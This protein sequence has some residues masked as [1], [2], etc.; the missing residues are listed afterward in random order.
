MIDLH[1]APTPNGWKISIMLE[2]LGMPYNVIPV[3]IRNGDQFKPE[4]LAI[5]PNNR[6][7]AIVDHAPMDGGEPL[8]MFETGAIL[9]YLAE[10]S[11]RFLP[12]DLRARFNVIQWLMWQM[13]GL[14]PMLGQHG[15]FA[16]YAPEKIPY[17][18]QRYRDEASRLYAVLNKQLGKTGAYVAGEYSIADIACFPWTMTHKA[19]GFTLDDFPHIKRWYA[20]VRARPKVQAGLAVGK[21]EKKPF[22]EE[23]RANMFGKA[24]QAAQ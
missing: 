15:H 24:A 6:I 17:A 22:T 9:I 5:S 16:L 4:F 18:I 19:Q 8:A 7:P 14:G 2:E 23:E 1:Y 20:D 21:F 13:G 11:G 12:T 3:N 10:K